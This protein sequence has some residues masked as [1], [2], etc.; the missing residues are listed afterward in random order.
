MLTLELVTAHFPLHIMIFSLNIS[1]QIREIFNNTY[2]EIF[3]SYLKLN[4]ISGDIGVRSLSVR[5][6]SLRTTHNTTL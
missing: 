6:P 5:P 2:V 1:T 4:I 3:C